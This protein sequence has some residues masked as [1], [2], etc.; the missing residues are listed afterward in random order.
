M[1]KQAKT[2]I[3]TFHD[4]LEGKIKLELYQKI[5][6][7]LLVMVIAGFAGWL[8]EFLLLE[9]SR[10]F[11]HMY[12]EGG[13]LLPWVNMYAY[14]AL[15]I[16]SLTRKMRN[17]PWLVFL[18]AAFAAGVMELVTG[19]AAYTFLD[20]A[21]YWDYSIPWWG[22]GNINGFVCPMSMFAFGLGALVLVYWLLPICI[23]ISKKMTRRAFLALVITLFVIVMTDEVVNLILKML[24]Q[25]TAMNLYESWGWRYK[26]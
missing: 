18:A 26:S 9:F 22:F 17:K 13:N 8:W 1:T 20:G 23:Y 25:P 10:G 15:L 19:W 16:I 4:Y 24:G 12:I 6:A 5:G 7:L 14:G 2:Y 21:R 3:D 11:D